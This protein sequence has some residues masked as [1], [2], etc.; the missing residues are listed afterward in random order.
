FST[1]NSITLFLAVTIG[2]LTTVPFAVSGAISLELFTLFGPRFYQKL[3]PTFISVVPLLITGPLLIINMYFY[4]GGS[5]E[6]GFQTRDLLVPSLVADRRVEQ[7]EEARADVV[8][9]AER[10]VEEL[11]SFDV[12]T[13]PTVTCP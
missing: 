1:F 8:A 2:G 5:A 13:G 7:E 3:G 11:E 12:V 6:A 4:P 9:A 10:H